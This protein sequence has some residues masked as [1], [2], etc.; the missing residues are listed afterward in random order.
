MIYFPKCAWMPFQFAP[1]ATDPA[2]DM[3]AEVDFYMQIFF[4]RSEQLQLSGI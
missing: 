2:T 3:H 4:T 1:V